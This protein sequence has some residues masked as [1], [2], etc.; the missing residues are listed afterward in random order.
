MVRALS[1]ELAK[2]AKDELNENPKQIANDLQ[3]IKEWISKQPHLIART[4]DQWLLAILRGCKFSLERVKVKLDL[5]YTLRTTAPEITLRLKPTRPEFLQ[6]LKLGT[7]LILPQS[8]SSLHPSVIMIRPG[9]YDPDKNNVADVMCILYYLV[10]I[11]V[12]ECDNA[13]VL[14]TKIVVDYQGC[15]MN[16][17]TQ[18]NPATLKKLVAV[19]QD[20]LPLR[21]KGSHHLNVPSGIEIV[22]KLISGF[23]NQKAKDRLKIHK[24]SDEL[25]QHLPKEIVPVEYGGT[26]KSIPEI[27]EYWAQKVTQHRAWLEEEM[28]YGTDE[29]KRQGSMPGAALAD[30]GSFR[31]LDID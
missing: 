30:Q 25:L 1:P 20:S 27:L 11:L 17:L 3:S 6:F 28:R 31:T 24:T 4:D 29:S 12:M 10:Q 14:G 13:T 15:T 7:C 8:A 9:L 2:I 16:H 26:G 23:L 22:F 19:S 18:A 5:F 21:L